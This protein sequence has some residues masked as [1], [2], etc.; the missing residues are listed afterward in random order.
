MLVYVSP[1]MEIDF[2]NESI[3]KGARINV[4]KDLD[5]PLMATILT[6]LRQLDDKQKQLRIINY[7][8]DTIEQE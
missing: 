6:L 4:Y 5:L 3:T 8:K 7:V 1:D 2:E